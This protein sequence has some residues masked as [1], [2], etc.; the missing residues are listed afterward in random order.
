MRLTAVRRDVAAGEHTS[1][2]PQRQ[3]TPDRRSHQPHRDT[4]IEHL[5]P[6]AEHG[7]GEVGVATQPAQLAGRD[8]RAVVE[9]ASLLS[10]L[11][12]VSLAHGHNDA[13]TVTCDAGRTAS[14]LMRRHQRHQ[15]IRAPLPG[16]HRID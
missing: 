12:Q 14:L 9:N 2:V 3:R 1:L 16:R 15:G 11:A 5:R 4:H 7:R 10:P 13:R 6:S 8:L